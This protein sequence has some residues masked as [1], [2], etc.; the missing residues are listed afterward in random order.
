MKVLVADN[1][2][3]SALDGIAALGVEILSEPDLKDDALRDRLHETGAEVLVVRSTKVTAPMIEGSGLKLIIRAGAGYNTIDVAA[4][5]ANKVYV[6]N[7]PGKNANAVAELA[8]G[9]MIALDRFIPDNVSELRAGK[10]NK[11]GF[12]KARGLAG[13]TLGL[14]G[15]GNIGIK[16]ADR[17]HAF[18]MKVIA[19]SKH[20]DDAEAARLDV[21][22]VELEEVAQRADI[23]SIHCALTPE[24]RGMINDAFFAAMKPGAF[25]INTSR[26]EVVDQEALLR[27]VNDKGIKAGLDV[28]D[29][30]PTTPEGTYSGPLCSADGVYCTHHIGASTEEAQEAVAAE[31]VAIVRD[32]V[33]HGHG[34]NAVNTF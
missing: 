28:F 23:V 32:F 30:E 6:T 22:L 16:V 26:A 24:T 13:R 15:L 17:A 31:T 33:A 3:K 1:L 10:W 20:H 9:L 2:E 5:T 19:Y 7:C 21:E 18:D 12:G 27:A 14:I 11:K 25:L 34:R 8:L 4:A 29:D